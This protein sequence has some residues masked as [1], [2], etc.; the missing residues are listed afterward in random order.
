MADLPVISGH[1]GTE[2]G[3]SRGTTASRRGG[4]GPHNPLQNSPTHERTVS[5]AAREQM[6]CSQIAPAQA[7]CV[8]WAIS[9]FAAG[10]V[11]RCEV[12][13]RKVQ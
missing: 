3:R 5:H 6:P 8:K 9:K 11:Q 13:S 12:I 2:G 4:L 1:D 7:S 10:R